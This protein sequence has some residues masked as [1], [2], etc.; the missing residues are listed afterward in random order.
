MLA[1]AG[2][3]DGHLAQVWSRLKHLETSRQ[4]MFSAQ[5]KEGARQLSMHLLI[6]VGQLCDLPHCSLRASVSSSVNKRIAFMH[7]VVGKIK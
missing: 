6:N 2:G 4:R 1:L 3:S 7:R 5:Q